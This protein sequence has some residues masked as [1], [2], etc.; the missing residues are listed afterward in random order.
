MASWFDSAVQDGMQRAATNSGYAQIR[1]TAGL[2]RESTTRRATHHQDK[3]RALS[4]AATRQRQINQVT[5]YPVGRQPA[6]FQRDAQSPQVWMAVAGSARGTTYEARVAQIKGEDS[7][8]WLPLVDTPGV[9]AYPS[10]ELAME[11]ALEAAHQRMERATEGSRVRARRM[12]AVRHSEFASAIEKSS[13]PRVHHLRRNE[14]RASQ[15]LREIGFTTTEIGK[16]LHIDTRI[17]TD[18]CE[19]PFDEAD[20]RWAGMPSYEGKR[21][22]EPRITSNKGAPERDE[23]ERR[24]T[25]HV[26]ADD[27]SVAFTVRWNGRIEGVVPD[28]SGQRS[29][30]V[31]LDRENVDGR[32]H[33]QARMA[34]RRLGRPGTRVRQVMQRAITSAREAMAGPAI[35]VASPESV[36]PA[37]RAALVT[38]AQRVPAPANRKT[39]SQVIADATPVPGDSLDRIQAA[40]AAHREGLK[41]RHRARTRLHETHQSVLSPILGAHKRAPSQTN[42]P[43]LG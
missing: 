41:S 13:S 3:A 22:V 14:I 42:E 23:N 21:V 37:E 1:H 6:S 7:S 33:W 30:A 12:K 24:A 36:S 2:W 38:A 11:F 19:C 17:V 8:H 9:Q 15:L 27:C 20:R 28:R 5:V 25:T 4:L 31:T 32:S 39:A 18:I 16:A 34:G 43:G 35:H 40:D 29:E 10:A 26:K